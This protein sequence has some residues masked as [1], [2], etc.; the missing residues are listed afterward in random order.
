MKPTESILKT[1]TVNEI[2]QDTINF[3]QSRV[4]YKKAVVMQNFGQGKNSV[5]KK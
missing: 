3:K 5:N 1:N 2:P 4:D